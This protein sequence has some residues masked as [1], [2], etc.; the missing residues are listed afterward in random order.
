MS[1]LGLI[2]SK[3]GLLEAWS[4]LDRRPHFGTRLRLQS[5]FQ[6]CFGTGMQ[7]PPAGALAGVRESS[8]ASEAVR[9]AG[10]AVLGRCWAAGALGPA[11]PFS[12]C[13]R[14]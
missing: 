3:H 2:W 4:L 7:H 10:G 11:C 6:G 9:W 1:S 14:M 5:E 8:R 12:G 13:L